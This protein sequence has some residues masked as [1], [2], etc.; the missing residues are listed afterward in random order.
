MLDKKECM[1]RDGYTAVDLRGSEDFKY[2]N[3]C[4]ILF[5]IP[6]AWINIDVSQRRFN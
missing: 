6:F 3:N 5:E 4:L 1:I 2:S